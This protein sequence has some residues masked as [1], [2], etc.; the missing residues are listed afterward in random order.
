[1]L[2][3]TLTWNGL[4]SVCLSVCLSIHFS[5]C[6]C[7][8]LQDYVS[9]H[10]VNCSLPLTPDATASQELTIYLLLSLLAYACT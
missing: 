10:V 5:F 9:V 8:Y 3:M 4:L 1:M 2:P 6:I 7:D